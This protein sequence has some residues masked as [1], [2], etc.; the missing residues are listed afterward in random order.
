MNKIYFEHFFRFNVVLIPSKYLL[1]PLRFAALTISCRS[2]LTCGIKVIFGE[3]GYSG[4]YSHK[5]PHEAR[6][7]Q[8]GAYVRPLNRLTINVPSPFL[9]RAGA[10]AYLNLNKKNQIVHIS[11]D[12]GEKIHGTSHVA[13]RYHG[14]PSP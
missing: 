13:G 1:F 5:T 2:V 7:Y 6:S 11:S 14:E 12:G 4:Q 3:G 10:A 9:V 8:S